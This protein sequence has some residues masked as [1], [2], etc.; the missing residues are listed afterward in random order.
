MSKT[1]TKRRPTTPAVLAAMLTENTGRALCDSG[2]EN[3]RMWQRNQG[4]DFE[5]LPA[6]NF[7][8]HVLTC[9]DG[10]V[11]MGFDITL[12][13]YHW[14]KERLT[15]DRKINGLYE[16]FAKKRRKDDYEL[17][18]MREFPLH[19]RE[20][21]MHVT[22]LYG[23][24]VR[25]FAAEN[26][27][28]HEDALSQTLQFVYFEVDGTPYVALQIHGGADV[29]GGY[30]QAKVFSLDDDPATFFDYG[31]VT[32]VGNRPA[33]DPDQAVMP[34][35][36]GHG[37]VDQVVWDSDNAG[38]SFSLES[39]YELYKGPSVTPKLYSDSNSGRENGFPYSA[40]LSQ[41]GK[42]VVVVDKAQNKLY[43]PVTGWELIP[44]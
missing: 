20:S 27:Y 43:C 25:E 12:N 10:S 7:E 38:Y 42:G 33:A 40:D 13:V 16:R 29:R 22:G 24:E 30:T 6:V 9:A 36:E 44:A 37:E 32:L 5:A 28:N 34:F 41:R 11:R 15:F 8:V 2:G 14:L 31:K 26:T 23:D 1:T 39:G 4:V 3:G 18:I 17:E 21:G 19:L 35:A